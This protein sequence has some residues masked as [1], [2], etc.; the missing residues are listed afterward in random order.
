M[1]DT[2]L[3]EVFRTLKMIYKYMYFRCMITY[4]IHQNIIH[5]LH[6]LWYTKGLISVELSHC[7]ALWEL[8]TQN[9][10]PGPLLSL[11]HI[12]LIF[13]PSGP[14]VKKGS[15][16]NFEIEKSLD[17]ILIK[18]LQPVYVLNSY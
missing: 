1:R 5:I 8:P 12:L 9:N 18:L 16:T 2:Y 7:S 11:R 4:V 15:G 14:D 13:W 6:V 17:V 3:L 10:T